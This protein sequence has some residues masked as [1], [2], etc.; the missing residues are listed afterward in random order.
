M[1]QTIFPCCEAIDEELVE[2]AGD[3]GPTHRLILR[4]LLVGSGRRLSLRTALFD[5]GVGAF[6]IR[7][8]ELRNKFGI[9][10]EHESVSFTSRLGNKGS[11]R[12]HW[13]TAAGRERAIAILEAW[14]AAKGGLDETQ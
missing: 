1:M 14:V 2:L 6:R 7:M 12:A 5:L 9:E 4:Y 8:S 13:L 11:Y 10:T 3:L